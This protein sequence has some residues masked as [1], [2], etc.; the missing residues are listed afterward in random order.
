MSASMRE[1]F[2]ASVERVLNSWTV[3]KLAVSHG[4]G[5]ADS[6]AKA[7][8]LVFA[9]DQWFAENANIDP[10]EVEDFLEDVL[11]TEFDTIVDDGSLPQIAQMICGFYK[12]CQDGN[13]AQLQERL[14]KL[15]KP[16]VQNCQQVSG[17]NGA[18]DSDSDVE[19]PAENGI[20]PGPP[21][22]VQ[23]AQSSTPP[24]ANNENQDSMEM[25]VTEDDGWTT[26]GKKGKRR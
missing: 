17:A 14:G 15:P 16:A 21:P 9:V 13:E 12:L 25:E 7:E 2:R 6:E 4:F 18:V 26:V 1:Q 22:L 5:G 23:P 8:W 19:D 24:A 11:N 10:Y 20:D 3:L